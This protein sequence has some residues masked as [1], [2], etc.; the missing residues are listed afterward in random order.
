MVE[1]R[2]PGSSDQYRPGRRS[3]R[4]DVDPAPWRLTERLGLVENPQTG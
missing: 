1:G 4:V 2:S 3:R